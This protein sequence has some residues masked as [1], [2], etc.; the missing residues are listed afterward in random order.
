MKWNIWIRQIHR[1]VSIAFTVTVIVLVDCDMV[2]RVA[3]AGAPN[4]TSPPLK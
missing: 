3:A 1:W 4:V 2:D